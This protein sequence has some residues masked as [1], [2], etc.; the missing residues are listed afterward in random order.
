MN[1]D[2]LRKVEIIEIEDN[3]K[4]KVINTGYFHQFITDFFFDRSRTMALI[5]NE[6]GSITKVPFYSIRFIS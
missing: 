2:N 5:E 3:D 4:I 6:D 1:R